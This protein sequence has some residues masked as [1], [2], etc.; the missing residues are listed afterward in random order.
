VLEN[1]SSVFDGVPDFTAELADSSVNG[2]VEW[3]EWNWH[4]HHVDGSPFAM[5]GSRS[6]SCA[7][8][9]RRRALVRGG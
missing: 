2:D 6:S 4:G 5:Q 1:C 3:G 8:A 7:R 9:G